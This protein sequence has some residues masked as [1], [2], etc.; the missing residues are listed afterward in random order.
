MGRPED[1]E[2]VGIRDARGIEVDLDGL[3]VVADRLV[4]GVSCGATGI[5]NARAND[6]GNLPEPGIRTP[7]STE[8]E[9]RR[10]EIGWCNRV[11]CRNSELA[12]VLCV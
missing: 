5:A 3:G 6:A 9:S 4:R 11:D 12:G 10:L 8:R 1:V 7:E 2:Q